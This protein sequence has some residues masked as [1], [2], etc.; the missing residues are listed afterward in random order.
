[1]APKN[2]K[3]KEASVTPTASIAHAASLASTTNALTKNLSSMTI[4][5]ISTK[6][7]KRNIVKEFDDYFGAD[8]LESWKRLCRHIGVDIWEQLSTKKECKKVIVHH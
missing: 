4:S 3:K 5:E 1:M 6:K 2:G 8:N 7:V